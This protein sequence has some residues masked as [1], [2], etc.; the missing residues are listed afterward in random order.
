M[1]TFNNPAFSGPSFNGPN[2]LLTHAL[3]LHRAGRFAQAVPVYQQL[4]KSNPGVPQVLDL[5]GTAQTSMGLIEEG[6]RNIEKAIKI[7]PQTASFHHDLSIGYRREGKFARSQ[8]CLDKALKLAPRHPVYTAAKA[9]LAF[10][11]GDFDRCMEVLQPVLSTAASAPPVAIMFGTVAPRV[12]REREAIEV[13]GR[14]LERTDLAPAQRTKAL[15]TLGALHDGL[16]EFEPAFDAFRRGNELVGAKFDGDHH[17]NVIDATIK[18][19]SAENL[20]TLPTA[21]VDASGIVFIVGM[22]R[23]G[24][25]LVE[26]IL[27]ASADVF[28][29]GELDH[30]LRLARQMPGCAPDGFPLI[31]SFAGLTAD[32]LTKVGGAYLDA[33]RKL[34][35][36]AKLI[37]DKLP[38]NFLGLGFIQ[39]ALPG[40]KIIHC[41]RDPMDTCLSCYFQLFNGNL[42]F[43]YDLEK[44]GRFYVEYERLMDHWKAVL[45]LPIL[46]VQY[47]T[48]V[49][50]QEGESRRI[51]EFVGLP[52]TDAALRFHESTRTALTS[53][54]V[55][56]RQPMYTR[57]V[58]RWKNYE[59]HLAPLM[60]GLGR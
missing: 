36:S 21:Q 39:H 12:K 33:V 31:T 56:V 5:L 4:L 55:Q 17:R 22:P 38:L 46:D 60:A 27:G 13:L 42:P 49:Q 9:E 16:D 28:P 30:M 44:A 18:A 47:E 10:M 8:D 53:S 37:I 6:R 2:P 19:W 3:S 24:T 11:T 23:S 29:A 58:A 41:R 45:T 50:D 34:A 57:S 43:A 35:P 59:R 40:A 26:Q 15:F 52:W 7:S 32:T 25:T 51:Y 54:N 20:A 1:S 48:M 14:V